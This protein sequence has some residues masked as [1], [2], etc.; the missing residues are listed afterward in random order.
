[1]TNIPDHA[2]NL[3]VVHLRTEIENVLANWVLARKDGSHQRL[4]HNSYKRFTLG[5]GVTKNAP[6]E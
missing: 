6:S 3:N 1:V 2:N 4:V 5:V